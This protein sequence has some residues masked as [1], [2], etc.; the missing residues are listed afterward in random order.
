MYEPGSW[1]VSGKAHDQPTAG[2]KKCGIATRWIVELET[3][4]AAIP[5]AGTLADDIVIWSDTLAKVRYQ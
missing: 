4:F 2:G 5:D 3:S 1:V